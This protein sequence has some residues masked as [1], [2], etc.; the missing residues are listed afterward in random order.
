MEISGFFVPDRYMVFVHPFLA[1]TRTPEILSMAGIMCQKPIRLM[2]TWS[3]LRR[4]VPLKRTLKAE[5][6]ASGQNADPEG[7]LHDM[8]L[9]SSS[10]Q[11]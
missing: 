4:P 3:S 9:A 8:S 10:F 1:F 6:Y 7:L 11:Y 5:S 2:K